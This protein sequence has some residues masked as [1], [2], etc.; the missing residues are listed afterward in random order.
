[1]NVM[2]ILI[3]NMK[4]QKINNMEYEFEYRSKFSGNRVVKVEDKNYS[5]Y[6]PTE[7]KYLFSHEAYKFVSLFAKLRQKD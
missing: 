4:S 1:M 3:L 5:Y 7:K 2:M 6:D